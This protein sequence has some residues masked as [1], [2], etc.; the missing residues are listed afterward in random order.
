MAL[1]G[2]NLNL[3]RLGVFLA[4]SFPSKVTSPL[5]NTYFSSC[6]GEVL[7][8]ARYH[9]FGDPIMTCRVPIIPGALVL[10]RFVLDRMPLFWHCLGPVWA[11]RHHNCRIFQNLT[12][13][14]FNNFWELSFGPFFAN[15]LR[16]LFLLTITST[17]LGNVSPSSRQRSS[18]KSEPYGHIVA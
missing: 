14:H 10:I 6:W 4:G 11:A 18:P 9:N 1:Y 8:S 3:I 7:N 15:S 2:N 12:K 5:P 13:G 17:Q 16:M